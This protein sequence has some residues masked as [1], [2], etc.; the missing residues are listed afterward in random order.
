MTSR[1]NAHDGCLR[2]SV[3]TPSAIKALYQ[4]TST[5][6]ISE[7][8]NMRKVEMDRYRS[9]PKDGSNISPK[10]RNERDNQKARD[11]RARPKETWRR[12]VEIQNMAADRQRWRSSVKALCAS[13]HEEDQEDKNRNLLKHSQGKLEWQTNGH[14]NNVLN[15]ISKNTCYYIKKFA[16]FKLTFFRAH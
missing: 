1:T 9:C 5:S 7:M 15:K 13:Q 12:S 6:P 11:N 16:L 4:R 8:I 14:T 3:P 2:Y 10:D